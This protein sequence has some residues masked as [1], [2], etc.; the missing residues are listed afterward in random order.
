VNDRPVGI[1]RNTGRG[2]DTATL[3]LR[4]SRGF[5]TGGRS[6]AEVI[7]EAFNVLNRSNFLIPNNIIGTGPAPAAGFGTPTAAADPRQVQL[8]VRWTF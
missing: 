7:I 5:R 6:R 3:D 4:L 1:G 8:G 2:F